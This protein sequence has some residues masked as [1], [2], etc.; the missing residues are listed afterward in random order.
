M[1]KLNIL[2]KIAVGLVALILFIIGLILFSMFAGCC[3]LSKRSCFPACEAKEPWVMQV[4]KPCKL[5]PKLDLFPVE[6]ETDQCPDDFICF[7]AENA[8]KLV[9]RLTAMRGWIKE[10]RARCGSE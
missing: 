9:D 10:A 2:E 5:P 8:V 7:D 3:H 6:R 4:E 1:Q